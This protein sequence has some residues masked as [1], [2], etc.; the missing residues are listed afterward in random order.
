MVDVVA[1]PG[2]LRLLASKAEHIL[3]VA[4]IG[5]G[6]TQA[7]VRWCFKQ[8]Y[9][10]PGAV[11]FIGAPSM[12][13]LHKVCV[14]AFTELM[15][16]IGLPYVCGKAPPADW[17]GTRF[18]DHHNVISV[19][20]P[21]YWRACQLFIGTMD[22]PEAH[23][24]KSFGWAWLDESRDMKE[25]AYDVVLA[26]LRGQPQGTVYRTLNTST[27]NGFNWL[28]GRFI[29]EE[30]PGQAIIRMATS[31]NCFLPEGFIERLRAQYTERFARQELDAEFLNMAAGQ[32]YYAFNRDKHI[33]P[34]SVKLDQPMFYAMDWNV[35]P[36][37]ACY[38]QGDKLKAGVLGEIYI[39]GSGRTADAADEFVRRTQ[40]HQN[41]RVI[42]YGDMSGANRDTRSN[43]TDYDILQSV[44]QKA[45]WATEI[46]RNFANPSLIDSVETVNNCLEKGNLSID[47][48]CK[49][50]VADLEQVCWQE[51]SRVLD[52]KN[53]DLTHVSDALRYYL[54][55]EFSASQ[56]ATTSNILN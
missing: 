15:N 1:L 50:L 34:V 46:R 55:K 3:C 41:K 56:R 49:K 51:G 10:Q 20:L 31:E 14:P 39:V 17:G 26:R 54:H 13:Q 43:T 37:C 16:Q 6:K 4:G 36:L 33:S 35:S 29:A 40:G 22:D 23:R 8:M 5:S 28:Y 45:G 30:K 52:K 48:S 19:R 2:Q 25:L 53:A 11:G 47:P 18:E 42:I 12:D 44:F 38:G 7:G 27:P 24:G 32:A 21:G 9:E